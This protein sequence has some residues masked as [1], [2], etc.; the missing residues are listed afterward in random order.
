V[1]RGIVRGGV[2]VLEEG[3]EA[4]PEGTRVM[5]I[6]EPSKDEE[7]ERAFERLERVAAEIARSA[8]STLNLGELVVEGRRELEE[9]G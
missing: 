4:L 7:R 6:P 3:A 1:L 2:V 8:P 9:R 5:V